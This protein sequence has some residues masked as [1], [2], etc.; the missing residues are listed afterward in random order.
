M[1]DEMRIVGAPG[2]G[3]TF[4][5]AHQVTSMVE[6]GRFA[7]GDFIL[8][9]YTRTAATELRGRIAVPDENVATLHALAYRSIGS[10]PIAEKAELAKQWDDAHRG[11]P[12]WQIGSGT[13]DDD[14]GLTMTDAEQGEML[15]A[16]S[17]ARAMLAP[18]H[19]PL[20]GRSEAFAWEW[21]AYKEETGSIDFTDMLIQAATFTSALTQPVLIVDEAQDLTPLQWFLVRQWG[22]AAQVFIVAGDPAQAV[23]SFAGARPDEMLTPIAHQRM[24]PLSYRLPA[25]VQA[26]AERWLVRHSGSLTVGREYRPRD[27]T[28]SVRGLPATWRNPDELV[29]DVERRVD[30]GRS[31]MVLASCAYMLAPTL[32]ALRER[33]L[34]FANRWR[35]S[36]GAWNPLGARARGALRTADRVLAYLRGEVK[37][38]P[39]LLRADVYLWRGAKKMVDEAGWDPDLLKPEYRALYDAGDP[40]LLLTGGFAKA[41]RPVEYAVR[42]AARNIH[43]LTERPLVTI[44][45]A[46]SVKGGEADVVYVFPDVSQAAQEEMEAN[47][48][49]QDAA[50]RLFYVAFTRAREELVL[51]DASDLRRATW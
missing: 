5:L 26:H 47:A 39:E 9:S 19:H 3:K 6:S 14:D 51:L 32:A 33:G 34:P 15:R 27:A 23:Y 42:L 7:P 30:E 20:W 12:S 2:T 10:P 28:G 8:T 16:Y 49:G 37:H 29:W 50:V 17:L 41:Q 38:W 4:A 25:T 13:V 36:N 1:A 11:L 18:P 24:L 48:A 35:T 45:T 46:H 22:A 40:L 44:G 43:A 31:V 21:E